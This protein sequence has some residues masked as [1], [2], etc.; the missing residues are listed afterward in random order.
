MPITSTSAVV[1]LDA[2]A[3]PL[4]TELGGHLTAELGLDGRWRHAVETVPRHRFVPGFYLCSDRAADNGLPLWEPVTAAID[5]ARWLTAI[6]Q[7]RTLNTQFEGVEPDWRHPAVQ[8]GGSATSSS[9]LPSLVLR[10]WADADLYSDH[11]ILEIGTGTGYSTALACEALGD[12]ADITSVEVDPH[13]LEQAARTLYGLGYGPAVATAD[14][15][16]GY[17]PHAPYDRIVAACSVRKI[18]ATWTAQTRPGGKI[19]TTLSGWMHGYGRVLLTVAGDGSASGP[20]L[21]GTISFMAARVHQPPNP[22]SPGHWKHLLTGPARHARHSPARLDEA[23]EESF[24]ARF[25][26]QLAA[27]NA[28][29]TWMD[30]DTY[31]IDPLS[32]SVALLEPDGDDWMIRQAGPSALW[33]DI[34]AALD[35]WDIA[36][37]PGLGEFR[38]HVV[39]DQQRIEL[40]GVPALSFT[41]P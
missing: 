15:L 32:A 35:A 37:N 38:M 17:W 18:P 13:R 39:G 16:Y 1:D 24:Y 30:G 2:A 36:G 12:D 20:L 26:A 29:M 21:P 33:D 5:P 10:M 23:T 7:D 28:V 31:L 34:S 4:R 22:G 19:L 3:V 14:G 25:I 40:P 9:T 6:Y 8:I 27:P 11:T 41:L